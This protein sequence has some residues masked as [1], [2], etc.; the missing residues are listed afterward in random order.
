MPISNRGDSIDVTYYL[1]DDSIRKRLQNTNIIVYISEKHYYTQLTTSVYNHI[2]WK[3]ISELTPAHETC[4]RMHLI[5]IGDAIH[6]LINYDYYFPNEF[7]SNKN[8][9]C[10]WFFSKTV[11]SVFYKAAASI[12]IFFYVMLFIFL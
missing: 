7:N 8:T 3:G 6:W 11:Y 9:A 1:D 2:L 4:R 12:W 5:W 10:L